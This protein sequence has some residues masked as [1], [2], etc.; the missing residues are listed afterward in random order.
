MEQDERNQY[1][2]DKSGGIVLDIL[3][4]GLLFITVTSVLFNMPV[5]YIS[6]VI[7]SFTILLKITAYFIFSKY[8]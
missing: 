2:H 8:S 1:L 5:F 3:L 6:V 7:L 4:I